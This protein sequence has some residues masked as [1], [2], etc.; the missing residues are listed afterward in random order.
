VPGQ[1]RKRFPRI[2]RVAL[3]QVYWILPLFSSSPK[4][5]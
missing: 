2:I 3:S 5:R 4:P 1:G